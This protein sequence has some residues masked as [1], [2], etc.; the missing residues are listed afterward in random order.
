MQIHCPQCKAKLTLGQPKPGK[1][2]PKCK[3]CGKAFLLKVSAD[4]PP[5]VAVGRLEP[6]SKKVAEKTPTSPS[7]RQPP[8][9]T[10]PGHA[11]DVDATMDATT[12][13]TAATAPDPSNAISPSRGSKPVVPAAIEQTVDSTT[14]LERTAGGADR[15]SANVDATVDQTAD[16][17]SDGAV[18]AVAGTG[19]SKKPSVVRSGS[20]AVA[21]RERQNNSGNDDLSAI[22]E[23]LGGYKIMKMLGRGAMGA[24]YEAKQISLDRIVALK[25]I[26]GRLANNPASL[27]RFTREAYA[28]AQLTHH[29]VVQ[30]YDFGEDDGKHFFSMEWV[31]GGPLS[32]IIRDKGAIDPKLAA[33][34]TLQAARGLQFAHQNGMVHRDVKPANLLLSDEGVVKVADLGLVK[35]PDQGDVDAQDDPQSISGL[36]SGTQVTMMGTA[37][38]TPAYMAPEQSIDA[39]SVDHR[40]DIYSLGCTLFF[41]LCGRPPFDGSVV[42]EVMEQHAKQPTPDL[43]QINSRVPAALNQIVHRAM[44]KRPGDRYGSLAEM[45]G[46]LEGYLG[47]SKDGS[48]SP[49]SEQADQWESIAAAF[50]K[51]TPLLRLA[52]PVA[53]SFALACVVLTLLMPFVGMRWLLFA[54]AL[55]LSAAAIAI[56]MAGRNSAIGTSLRTWLDSLSWI[57][58]I[59]AVVVGV[60]L[61][62]VSLATGI[63]IGLLAGLLV[64]AIAGSAYHFGLVLPTRRA[65][66]EPIEQAGK[67]I[68]DLRIDGADED[69]VRSFAARYAGKN[70]QSLYE[71]LF[72][73]DSLCKM[74][75]QLGSD[76]SFTRGSTRGGLRDKVAAK[77]LSKADANHQ[78][79]DQKRLA[80][81][82]ERGLASQGVSAA[83]ARQQAWQMAQAIIANAHSKSGES[84]DASAAAEIK[85]Q[86]QKAMLAEARSGK[87]AKKRDP[88]AIVKFALGGQTRLLLGCLLLGVFAI[89]A[90]NTG[91]VDQVTTGDVSVETLDAPSDAQLLGRGTSHWS[92]GIAGLLLCMSAFIS[93]WRMS[94]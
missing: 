62:L 38:G 94:P 74:R 22:P 18:A 70:W 15:T 82:E 1:F 19:S 31:R 29:N 85:R 87:Y 84:M 49:S 89:W 56:V 14:Q 37:V 55:F 77:F 7:K 44:A 35:I 25:T 9:S 64:G 51:Q 72:G 17:V 79:R 23:R 12:H 43:V 60:V 58:Y 40:A 48:F 28:A 26:R 91:L 2:R 20:R 93:G 52:E 8:P 65:A 63:W 54:P 80:K 32:D 39:A 3:H 86:Q 46:D 33:G 68:R 71:S 16:G 50:R 73:Y 76:P 4:N 92:I 83:E 24:V 13:P 5:K 11:T 34:Y 45:I 21:A 42:S 81:I 30:I 78:S 67:F 59:V 10:S 57:D 47:V 27:A 36:Q 61:L 75:E 90:Q 69:G 41:M 88:F 6:A 53:T 66:A